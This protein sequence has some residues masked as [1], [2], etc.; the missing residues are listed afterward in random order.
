MPLGQLKHAWYV[1]YPTRSDDGEYLID[2]KT[3]KGILDWVKTLA[4]P[5]AQ[6]LARKEQVGVHCLGLHH[7]G[8]MTLA[9]LVM[10]ITGSFVVLF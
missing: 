6:R 9:C 3:G 1:A 7:R 5:V 2:R 4:S 10:A 8:P